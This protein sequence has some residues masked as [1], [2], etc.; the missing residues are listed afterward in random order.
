MR[1]NKNFLKIMVLAGLI[2]AVTLGFTFGAVAEEKIGPITVSVWSGPEH[3]NLVKCARYYEQKTGRKVFIEEIAREALRE[4]TTTVLMAKKGRYDVSYV[5]KAWIGGYAKAR[6]LQPLNGFIEDPNVVA[7]WFS[8]DNLKPPIDDLAMDGKIYGFP[9]EGDCQFLFW[10]TDLFNHPEEKAAFKAKYGYELK[11]PET[12]KEY[13]DVARFFTRKKGERLAGK[14]LKDDFYGTTLEGKRTE[15][16]W[17]IATFLYGYQGGKVIDPET[18]EVVVNKPE[19]VAGFTFYT[20]LLRKWHVVSP[21]VPTWGYPEVSA[22]FG[23]GHTAMAIQ[24]MAAVAEFN[25][26]TRSPGL[27]KNGKRLFEYTVVP[28]REIGGKIK[29]RAVQAS[30]WGWIIP[31]NAPNPLGAYKF[32]EWLTGPEGAKMWAL[33]GGIPC[34]KLALTDSEVLEK[35]PMFKVLAESYPYRR[36][37]P[38]YVKTSI[39]YEIQDAI[40]LACN[41]MLIGVKTPQEAADELAKTIEEALRREGYI[42]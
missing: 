10:R 36:T 32:I 11:V 6:L 13:L 41:Q 23:G 2:L 39:D 16:C 40:G 35:Q 1:I 37:I 26:P 28:G 5:D 38:H 17:E 14:I 19:A 12:W 30:Q 25:D 18:F 24:W 8:V 27:W 29:Y 20:D 42:K 21:D 22:A 7:S 34:N 15:A 9:S 33:N 3:D 4:K 31:A